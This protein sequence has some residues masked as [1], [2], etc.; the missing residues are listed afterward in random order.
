MGNHYLAQTCLKYFCNEKNRLYRYS[1]ADP[2]NAI[3][4]SPKSFANINNYYSQLTSEGLI[5]KNTLEETFNNFETKW[6]SFIEKAFNKDNI[7]NHLQYD[8]DFITQQFVRVP[9]QRDLV[10]FW[11]REALKLSGEILEKSGK[12][13][14]FENKKNMSISIDPIKAHAAMVKFGLGLKRRI[15]DQ[16]GIC[17]L[18]NTTG[19]TFL[20]S[21]SPVIF[22]NPDVLEGQIKPYNIIPGDAIQLLFPIAKNLLIYGDSKMKNL[23]FSGI[24]HKELSDENQVNK[25]NELICQ[26]AYEY[27]FATDT[28]CSNLIAAYANKS[29]ILKITKNGNKIFGDRVFGK[30]TKP[31]WKRIYGI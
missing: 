13:S 27:I 29:P 2:T 17:I 9:C 12:I 22:F 7:D 23:A 20:T 24:E 5:D 31:Q 16:I 19:I 21:D 18:H 3:F 30:R 10:Y 25:F 11:L 4:S 8:H 14:R 1:K 26:F 6:P 15:L 28:N